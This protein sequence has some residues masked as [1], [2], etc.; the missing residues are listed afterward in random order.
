MKTTALLVKAV[1][2]MACMPG[3][4]GCQQEGA[5]TPLLDN[6]LSQWEMYLSYAHKSGYA[7]E[8]PLDVNGDTVMPIGYNQNVKQ[9]F[10][11]QQED[12]SPV[13][14][15]SGE[16]Y[17]CVFTRQVYENYHL[18]L[19]VKWGTRKWEPRL[20][21]PMDSGILYHSQGECGHDY[22]RSWM[23]SQELQIM[24]ASFGDYWS[25][26][27]S[28]IDI[29]ASKPDGSDNFRYDPGASPV[30]FG[31]NTGNSGYCQHS[32]NAEYPM[33]EW[34]TV[35]LICF[36]GKSLHIVNGHVVMALSDSRYIDPVDNTRKPLTKGKIQLQ[37]EAAEVFYKD[38]MIREINQL[39][40]K[41]HGFFE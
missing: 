8:I 33:G 37:S 31:Y 26:M 21:D 5:W 38:I 24:E 19:K 17:G 40:R 6:N 30:S 18:K 32:E 11:M 13:L 29:R 41:Y 39:P 28:M 36:E 4:W 25:Q 2:V 16:I 9:V 15:I 14:K 34:N 7:G 20:N 1:L 10:A 12:G 3:L 22:W 23:L 35:E 27:T